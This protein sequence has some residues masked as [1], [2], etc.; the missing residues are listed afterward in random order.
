MQ[1]PVVEF[2][3]Q[4]RA[5]LALIQKQ[6]PEF[7]N[8]LEHLFFGGGKYLRP[9][10]YMEAVTAWKGDISIDYAIG[11]EFL[12]C[13]FLV[14]DDIMDGDTLRRDHPT[15]HVALSE[16]YGSIL[17]TGLGIVLGDMLCNEAMR[18]FLKHSTA[19]LEETFSTIHAVIHDTLVGQVRESTYTALPSVAELLTLYKKKTAR[20]SIFLPLYLAE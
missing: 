17:G 16:K 1:P 15:A 19:H 9:R 2:E 12:H 3:Q 13:Y 18:C 14:H 7:E 8:V 5:H 6:F 11:L 10:L 20:Y 4:L